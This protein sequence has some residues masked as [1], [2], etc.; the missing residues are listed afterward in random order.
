MGR[1]R[2]KGTQLRVSRSSTTWVPSGPGC[3]RSGHSFLCPEHLVQKGTRL[4][5]IVGSVVHGP[6]SSPS[7][8]FP[9]CCPLRVYM[10]IL[11]ARDRRR[12]LPLG[13]VTAHHCSSDALSSSHAAPY[14]APKMV[15]EA[16]VP[17]AKTVPRD[18]EGGAGLSPG[19]WPASSRALLLG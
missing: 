2:L 17:V 16:H 11:S 4:P 12:P 8:R 5:G 15:Q 18:T 19:P 3:S 6:A 13:P 14:P 10:E 9:S 1:L 7:Q